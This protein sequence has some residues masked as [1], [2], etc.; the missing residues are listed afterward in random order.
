MKLS[1]RMRRDELAS[2]S[3]I[4]QAWADEVAMLEAKY[5]LMEEKMEAYKEALETSEGPNTENALRDARARLLGEA[6]LSGY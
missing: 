3:A 5:D 2:G 1:K 4:R 6:E